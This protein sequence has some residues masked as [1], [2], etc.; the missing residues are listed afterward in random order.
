MQRARPVLAAVYNEN[1]ARYDWHASDP[2][3][4]TCNQ[5]VHVKLENQVGRLQNRIA[6]LENQMVV[7]N[8]DPNELRDLQEIVLDD[9]DEIQFECVLPKPIEI[10]QEAFDDTSQGINDSFELNHSFVSDNEVSNDGEVSTTSGRSNL[11]VNDNN[12]DD[13]QA[14]GNANA[15]E[16]ISS[17]IHQPNS[18]PTSI[19]DVVAGYIN[20]TIDVSVS[21][22]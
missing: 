1:L 7:A 2:D 19:Y 18:S 13:E 20:K 6:H 4:E 9:E 15:L 10:K 21:R 12:D 22:A 5:T 17:A 14:N 8:L 11:S 16:T 3:E